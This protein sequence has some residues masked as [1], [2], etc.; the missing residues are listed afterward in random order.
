MWWQN[1]FKSLDSVYTF[2]FFITLRFFLDGEEEGTGDMSGL[3]EPENM[4]LE[5][6]S[7]LYEEGFQVQVKPILHLEQINLQK[8]TASFKKSFCDISFGDIRKTLAH[9]TLRILSL[10]YFKYNVSHARSLS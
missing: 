3:V 4:A 6:P 10:Y 5:F 9:G 1:S 7:I 2:S 8:T